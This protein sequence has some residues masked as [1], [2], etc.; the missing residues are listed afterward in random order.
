MD[1]KDGLAI[2]V[3]CSYVKIKMMLIL[4]KTLPM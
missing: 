1:I 2:A 4:F 3:T